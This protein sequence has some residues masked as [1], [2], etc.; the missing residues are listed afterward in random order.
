MLLY[1]I[2]RCIKELMNDNTEEVKIYNAASLTTRSKFDTACNRCSALVQKPHTKSWAKAMRRL[3]YRVNKKTLIP[4]IFKLATSRQE[5]DRS[6]LNTSWVH[7]AYQKSEPIIILK[8]KSY[9][10]WE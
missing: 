2:K 4:F 10:L 3:L 1:D 7:E 8:H 6:C 5:F 9:S